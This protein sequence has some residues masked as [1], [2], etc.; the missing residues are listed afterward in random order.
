MWNGLG[1]AIVFPIYAFFQLRNPPQRYSITLQS[2]KALI[3]ALVLGSYLPSMLAV[4][5]P[6]LA[7]E[8]LSHQTIIGYFQLTPLA[9]VALHYIFSAVLSS[10]ISTEPASD[11]PWIRG[12]LGFAIAASS[13]THIYALAGAFM[14][15]DISRSI[16]F[17]I[18]NALVTAADVDKIALGAAFFLQWDWAIINISTIAWG[19]FLVREHEEVNAIALTLGL[20]AVNGL[21]GPGAMMSGVFY[22]REG[23]VRDDEAGR[24]RKGSNDR[25]TNLR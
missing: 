1:A 20:A 2:A 10:S 23:R 6:L 24:Q 22:W 3:P 16:F 18:S 14:S 13:M 7:R 4:A 19:A 9:V 21:L 12:A 15:R 25:P 11:L 5:P 17:G 8:P